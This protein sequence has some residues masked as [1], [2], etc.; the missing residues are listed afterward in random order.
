MRVPV[1]GEERER[2]SSKSDRPTVVVLGSINMDLVVQTERVPEAGETIKGG[3]LRTAAGGKGANQAVAAAR[4]GAEVRMVGRV[5]GDEFGDSL[6]AGL[7]SYGVDVAGVTVDERQASGVAIILLDADKENRIVVVSGANMECGSAEATAVGRALDGAQ[8]LLLQHEI[9]MGVNLEAARRA[10]EAG[11]KVIWNPAPFEQLP[12]EAYSLIDVIAP[13]SNEAAV[14]SGVDVTDSTSAGEAALWLLERGV[15]A[16][17]VTLGELGAVYATRRESGYVVAP[18]VE[19]V[20]TV[21]AGDAFNGALAVM[22][23]EGRPLLDAVRYG[24]MA[25]TAA[26]TRPGAQDGM[27][28][29]AAAATMLRR[30]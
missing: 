27:P 21:G 1:V 2:L 12:D 15:G 17:V 16:A 30:L 18:S 29:R 9:P 23:A 22:L 25:G 4:L 6:I 28:D 7:A 14:L 26:V 8:A 5:G 13:N 10:F 3:E 20:D 11:V 19:L 24:V